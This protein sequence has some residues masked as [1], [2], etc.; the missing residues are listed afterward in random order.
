MKKASLKKAH[1]SKE[2]KDAK[3]DTSGLVYAEQLI[4]II[5][6]SCRD[7]DGIMVASLLFLP[8]CYFAGLKR[9]L[10]LHNKKNLVMILVSQQYQKNDFIFN[11]IYKWSTTTA[12]EA[13]EQ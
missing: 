1:F 6:P 3:W 7:R 2:K 8:F 9:K 13:E 10:A 12:K 11:W 5:Q 4:I